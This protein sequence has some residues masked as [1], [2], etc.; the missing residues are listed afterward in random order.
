MAEDIV[1]TVDALAIV[2]VAKRS[3]G[4]AAAEHSFVAIAMARSLRSD[5][6]MP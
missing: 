1:R 5:S 3:P 4:V 2:L 6:Q